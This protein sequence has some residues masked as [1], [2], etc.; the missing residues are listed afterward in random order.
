MQKDIA[1]CNGCSKQKS[2]TQKKKAPI[3]TLPNG[4]PMERIAMDIMTDL[5]ET[6]NR[7]KHIQ[8]TGNNDNSRLIY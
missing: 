4:S 5:P 3:Q 7:Y 6:D 2:P 1:G 8:C